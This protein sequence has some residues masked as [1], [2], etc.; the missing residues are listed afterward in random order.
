MH[1]LNA[2]RGGL[3]M[4]ISAPVLGLWAQIQQ[5]YIQIETQPFLE[6]NSVSIPDM[7]VCS[8]LESGMGMVVW[9]LLSSIS[10]IHSTE[11]EMRCEHT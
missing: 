6:F 7:G 2:T 1:I 4:V 8:S 10:I 11:R 3:E 9:W 5:I